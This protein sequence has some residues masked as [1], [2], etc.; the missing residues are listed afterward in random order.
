MTWQ[1]FVNN[2]SRM[3]VGRRGKF[4]VLPPLYYAL[5]SRI[6][7]LL[8]LERVPYLPHS[9]D[10]EPIDICNFACDHCQV[11]HWKRKLATR[12]NPERFRAILRQVPR[13]RQITLQ[14]MGEPLLN[15]SLLDMLTEADG[16]GI[17]TQITSNGSIYTNSIAKRLLALR[18]VT[19]TFS[20]DGATAAT[21]EAIRVNGKFQAVIEHIT[22]LTRRRDGRSWPRI[23]ITT[24]ATAR[25]IHELPDLVR[26]AKKLGADS[27]TIRSRLT[28][29]GK[30]E[31]QDSIVPI[32]ISRGSRRAEQLLNEAKSAGAAIGMPLV[33][34]RGPRYSSA[35]RCRWPWNSAYIAANGDV[36]PC[37]M[38]GDSGVVK[39]GNVFA[40]PFSQIWNNDKYR[41]LRR[42]I[43]NDDIP[44]YCRSCYG[45]RPV[46]A[47]V[48]PSESSDAT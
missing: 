44:N 15:K 27:L 10:V 16:R 13:I 20:I 32:N 34:T 18:R 43:A 17:A 24:V 1:K 7:Q 4:R 37:C 5:R 8:K 31:M 25:N 33:I 12:L 28:D 29:F 45:M 23:E 26:L 46:A 19:L 40:E 36:V 30:D 2:I 11:T 14:G 41:T 35:R 38:I 39:M 42:R 9:L 48:A 3:Q 47:D 22:D 21:F 6:A